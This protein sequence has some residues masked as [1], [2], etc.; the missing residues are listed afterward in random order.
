MVAGP[1]A[2]L[3][4]LP[5]E[6]IEEYLVTPSSGVTPGPANYRQLNWDSTWQTQL[7]YL[8]NNSAASLF[9]F[10]R[11][12]WPGVK[13]LLFRFYSA[14]SLSSFSVGVENLPTP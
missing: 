4:E 2:I 6:G 11:L 3:N 10:T 14:S 13:S 5:S 8:Y 12:I 7:G 1:V 9:T